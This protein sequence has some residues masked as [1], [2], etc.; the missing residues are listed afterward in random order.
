MI[1]VQIDSVDPIQ[2]PKFQN[3][4]K[5]QPQTLIKALVEYYCSKIQLEKHVLSMSKEL[6]P[7]KYVELCLDT[8]LQ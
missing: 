7:L 2:L 3:N 4:L 8:G 5:C 1:H 6:D